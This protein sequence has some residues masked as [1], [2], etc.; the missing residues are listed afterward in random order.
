MKP[1]CQITFKGL[2]EVSIEIEVWKW[3]GEVWVLKG[4]EASVEVAGAVLIL[5]ALVHLT[6]SLCQLKR[7]PD[8]F[9]WTGRQRTPLSLIKMENHRTERIWSVSQSSERR[10]GENGRKT[11]EEFLSYWRKQQHNFLTL[12]ESTDH[13]SKRKWVYS[14][15]KADLNG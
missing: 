8:C 13:E 9:K 6:E 4:V 1:E 12:W 11:Q 3:V 5:K 10:D 15:L 2:A 14:R 7:R